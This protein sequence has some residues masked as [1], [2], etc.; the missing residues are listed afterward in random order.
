MEAEIATDLERGKIVDP[1]TQAKLED[2]RSLQ[3]QLVKGIERFY[4]FS[5]LFL[6]KGRT[7]CLNLFLCPC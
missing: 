7:R 5:L 2:A 1:A 6:T 4:E 3:E